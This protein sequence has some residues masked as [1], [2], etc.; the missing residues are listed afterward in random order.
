MA[1]RQH[2]T[3]CIFDATSPRMEWIHDYSQVQDH[4]LT[5]IQT[6]GTKR[7]VFLK[8]VDDI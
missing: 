8:F 7:Q 1:E 2:T 3:F 6:D 5:M 4:S